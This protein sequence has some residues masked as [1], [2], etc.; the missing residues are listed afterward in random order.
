[1]LFIEAMQFHPGSIYAIVG[2]IGSG[3][4]TLLSDIAKV[5]MPFFRSSG[6][7]KY[8]VTS[9][10]KTVEEIFCGSIPFSPPA[11]TL[12]ERLTYRIPSKYVETNKS[13]LEEASLTL[14]KE[15]GQKDFTKE[16]LSAK[17]NDASLKLSTGQ[18][19]IIMLI[20]A[21]LYKQYLKK[22]T[23]FVLDE[24]LANLDETT[25]KL[26]CSTIKKQFK[27]SIVISVDHNA[28]QNQDFYDNLVDL[29]QYTPPQSNDTPL[30][31]EGL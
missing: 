9:D 15:L 4:T 6:T 7:I 14:F 11:T 17:G 31:G 12:L 25:T 10:G 5:M 2:T 8:P 26:V 1:M 24:T 29:A 22:P 13:A 20:S 19:K 23:L 27:D 3:K 21:I 28:R 30:A 18:G 16:I